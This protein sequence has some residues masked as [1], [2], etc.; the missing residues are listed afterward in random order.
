MLGWIRTRGVYLGWGSCSKTC[1]STPMTGQISQGVHR[2]M[3]RE[4]INV[5]YEELE[6]KVVCVWIDVIKY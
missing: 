4:L 2:E 1:V 3:Q 6:E 5:H